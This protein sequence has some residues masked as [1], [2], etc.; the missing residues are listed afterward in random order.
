VKKILIYIP[1]FERY[2]LLKQNLR[3]INNQLNN[4]SF[5]RVFVSDN[6]QNS[7]E[8]TDIKSW[9]PNIA[10][11][12]YRK[13]AGNIG[14]NANIA[15]AFLEAQSDEI[16]WILAD[17][18]LIAS[19]AIENL[20][21]LV[22]LDA[23][24][25]S[26][27]RGFSTRDFQVRSFEY[28]RRGMYSILIEESWGLISSCLYNMK[29]VSP[30][31]ENAYI[32]FNASA[33]HLAVL[34]AAIEKKNRVTVADLNEIKLHQGN[35][36]G[37]DYSASLVGGPQLFHLAPQWERKSLAKS[38]VRRQ[39]GALYANKSRHQLSFSATRAILV[40]EAGLYARFFLAIGFVEVALRKSNLGQKMETTFR[41]NRFVLKIY[42][43]TGRIKYSANNLEIE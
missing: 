4:E 19:D 26:L 28:S 17:D 1:T 2:E 20:K 6:S 22:S 30:H 8:E 13:N 14:G 35:L 31:L 32:Y 38:W 39:S 33:P 25:Y 16:L 9:V 36:L 37:G 7:I 18:T 42:A 15:G 24:I 23:D 10:N 21:R 34:F 11:F 5:V 43:K 41:N 27:T 3:L 40:K 29:F 12:R